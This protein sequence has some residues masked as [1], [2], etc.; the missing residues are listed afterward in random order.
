MNSIP[1][2]SKQKFDWDADDDEYQD[3]E[4]NNL[5]AEIPGVRVESDYEDQALKPTAEPST[6]DLA[7]AALANA[8]LSTSQEDGNIA[9]VDIAGNEGPPNLVHPDSSDDEDG[10][11]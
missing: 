9:G 1:Q 3:L 7:A 6:A 8:N 11:D 4:T 5:I 10:D 2:L